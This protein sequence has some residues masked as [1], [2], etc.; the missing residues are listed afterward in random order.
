MRTITN[1]NLGKGFHFAE[2]SPIS[3]TSHVNGALVNMSIVS[4]IY[5]KGKR[6]RNGITPHRTCG[7]NSPVI[8]NF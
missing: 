7:L 2:K 4:Q 5:N 3:R 8:F 6:N 1:K